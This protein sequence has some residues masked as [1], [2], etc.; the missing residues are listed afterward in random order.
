[1]D[2]EEVK[3]LVELKINEDPE[4]YEG[5][6]KLHF[7]IKF[8]GNTMAG[9]VIKFKIKEHPSAIYSTISEY[10]T[11][12]KVSERICKCILLRLKDLKNQNII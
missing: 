9:D 12:Y 5:V 6:E 2:I 4:S 1:M 8:I 10:N 11:E 3:R 7:S